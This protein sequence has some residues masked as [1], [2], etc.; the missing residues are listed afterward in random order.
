MTT[1]QDGRYL[2][3]PAS[4]EAA[5]VGEFLWVFCTAFYFF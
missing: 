2:L 5:T 4:R 1:V 3:N